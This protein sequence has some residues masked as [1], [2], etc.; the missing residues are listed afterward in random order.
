MQNHITANYII[1]FSES[2]GL[3]NKN[4]SR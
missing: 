2:S 3:H 4:R 1:A